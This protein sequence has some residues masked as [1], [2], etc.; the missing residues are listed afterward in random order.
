MK[1]CCSSQTNSFSPMCLSIASRRICFVILPSI[2]VRLTG[3]WF[4]GSSFLSF[5]ETSAILPF[6]QPSGTSPDCHDYH[7]PFQPQVLPSPWSNGLSAGCPGPASVNTAA[8]PRKTESC[9]PSSRA[10]SILKGENPGAGKPHGGSLQSCFHF[11]A[12]SLAVWRKT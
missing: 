10:Y 12:C 8:S 11:T 9:N 1:P 3:W 4:L 7:A 2:E 5:L 6:F